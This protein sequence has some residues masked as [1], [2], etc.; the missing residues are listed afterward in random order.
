MRLPPRFHL[1][2]DGTLFKVRRRHTITP[3][4]LPHLLAALLSGDDV[5]NDVW[6]AYGLRV[7]VEVDTD[8]GGDEPELEDYVVFTPP[9]GDGTSC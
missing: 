1:V 8:Q 6:A 3:G 2:I 7:D 4:G 5:P 9:A